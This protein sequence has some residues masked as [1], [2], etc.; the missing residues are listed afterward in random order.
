MV[1]D[2]ISVALML[3]LTSAILG[4]SSCGKKSEGTG[5]VNESKA[6]MIPLPGQEVS[7]DSGQLKIDVP[8]IVNVLNT[9]DE[10][11][12]PGVYGKYKLKKETDQTIVI[13]EDYPYLSKYMS[14]KRFE[15]PMEAIFDAGVNVF[16]NLQLSLD[17]VNNTDEN[18]DITQL[19][20]KV[21][22]SKLDSIPMIYICTTE[23]RSNT[24]T[25][26]NDSWFNWGDMTFS[27][28][29][30][31]E[32]ENFDGKYKK[33]KKIAHFE[34]EKIVDLLPDLTEMGY[35]LPNAITELKKIY[36]QEGARGEL[37]WEEDEY[38]AYLLCATNKQ[39]PD[40]ERINSVFRPFSLQKDR[41][42]DYIG[43]A[44]LYGTLSFSKSKF[45]VDFKANISLSTSGGF[46]A[47][48]YESDKF[49]VKLKTE[50][51]DYTLKYPY[52]TVIKP[53]G[54][55]YVR[56]VISADKSSRHKFHIVARNNN[57][58]NIRSKDVDLY[59]YLPK[60]RKDFEIMY[61]D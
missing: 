32:G 49:N 17:I 10:E 45:K 60:S 34:G 42:D 61:P 16:T 14:G 9:V 25:F 15:A 6:S 13:D 27:Y 37:V 28:S 39:D 35:D 56:I 26:V 48:S 23:D 57:N 2:R 51:K 22:E 59:F 52:A 18:I 8:I 46:G 12:L 53:G 55:E 3:F 33:K 4:L 36:A 21:D 5:N 40:F 24:I 54:S 47:T 50:G 20:I 41:M 29:I 38:Y 11:S 30:L 7:N 44:Q 58:L 1:T 19:E 43:M 31:K